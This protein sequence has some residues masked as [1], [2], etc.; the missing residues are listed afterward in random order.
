MNSIC[1]FTQ[2]IFLISFV[3]ADP[4]KII[5]IR[6]DITIN[7]VPMSSNII[8][9]K[10]TPQ[11]FSQLIMALKCCRIDR[12]QVAGYNGHNG[13]YVLYDN[14][15]V[16]PA[17]PLTLPN[18]GLFFQKT[19]KNIFRVLCITDLS[20]PEKIRCYEPTA[21]IISRC[22]CLAE[23]PQKDKSS[24]TPSCSAQT[25]PSQTCLSPTFPQTTCL[26]PTCPSPTFPQTTCSA[27]ACPQPS[28]STCN[29]AIGIHQIP[30]NQQVNINAPNIAAVRHYCKKTECGKALIKKSFSRKYIF[31]M[32]SDP[33]LVVITK[34]HKRTE[35]IID[36]NKP[37]I[38]LNLPFLNHR[39]TLLNVKKSLEKE[40]KMPL[41]LYINSKNHLLVFVNQRL[42]LVKI[43]GDVI[44]A[45]KIKQECISSFICKG[46][47]R[48]DFKTAQ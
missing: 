5:K 21:T 2:L 7:E 34:K 48:I 39:D 45:K 11:N 23:M 12:A 10:I 18:V 24:I 32:K 9:A 19:N 43:N 3:I 41:A 37:G 13:L 20:N 1:I 33:S 30:S 26:S 44:Q 22:T 35:E 4:I 40:F 15:T 31:G 25:C 47:S 28:C 42:H 14:G 16:V 29:S 17:E 8:P 27:P 6:I 36:L 38:T 46:L